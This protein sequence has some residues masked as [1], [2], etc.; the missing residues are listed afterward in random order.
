MNQITTEEKLSI[1]FQPPV[2]SGNP[3]NH[4]LSM[5]VGS[6]SLREWMN[7][8]FSNEKLAFATDAHIL[9]SFDK[10]LADEIALDEI[11]AA[12][13]KTIT[14][15]DF[16]LSI[17]I[18]LNQ[19]KD[20]LSN[21]AIEQD[22]DS[23]GKDIEC[24]ACDGCGE[25]EVYFDYNDREYEIMAE[26]PICGGTGLSHRSTKIFNGKYVF[27]NSDLIR[28]HNAKYGVNYTHKMYQIAQILGE[29][30]ITLV[31]QPGPQRNSIFKIGNVNVLL[32]PCYDA[33]GSR[34]THVII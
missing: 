25:V 8:P 23:K 14:E 19:F 10:S 22:Y 34:T 29:S 7:V 9:I 27:E 21:C 1:A 15:V 5:C 20:T 28:I 24:D 13:V 30:E 18:P 33:D 3:Y 12:K 6:D 31:Y 16:N 4:I 32:M 2:F 26:C 17:P 11:N